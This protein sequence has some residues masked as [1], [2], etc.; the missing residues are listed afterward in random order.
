VTAERTACEAA[1]ERKKET[2]LLIQGIL[3]T[4][5]DLAP[6]PKNKR[7][8]ILKTE[9]EPMIHIPGTTLSSRP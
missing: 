2:I 7:E 6:E 4:D 1:N 8:R 5:V 3:F 9:I